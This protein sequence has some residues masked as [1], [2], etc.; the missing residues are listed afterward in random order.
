MLNWKC[1]FL[2]RLVAAETPCS[3]VSD[4]REKMCQV[5]KFSNKYIYGDALS[6]RCSFGKFSK[7]E[8]W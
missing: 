4:Y 8:P 3:L 5:I 7:N 6:I 2:N 1:K